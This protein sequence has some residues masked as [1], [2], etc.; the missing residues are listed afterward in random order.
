MNKYVID[1][2][3]LI[4]FAIFAP[5]NFHK[6]FWKALEDQVTK[7][8]IIIIDVVKKECKWDPLKSW[9]NRLGTYIVKT[10]DIKDR[11][12]EINNKYHLI[13]ETS[14]G[15]KSE[16]DPVIIAYAAKIDAI[17]FS[18]EAKRKFETDAMKMP[19]VCE[20][21]KI[22][23]ERRPAKVMEALKFDPI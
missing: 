6:S 19:D 18:Y 23:Y 12:A 20:K 4:N 11:A 2:N 10:D 8:N 1:T 17:V 7:Q 14:E 15:P 21:L 5:M 22:G 16:A 3:I 13:T 9:V